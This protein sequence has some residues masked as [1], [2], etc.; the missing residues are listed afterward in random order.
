MVKLANCQ[1]EQNE[2]VKLANW[3]NEQNEQNE[4]C[5]FRFFPFCWQNEMVR[6]ANW[7]NE[8]NCHLLTLQF[9]SAHSA[10]FANFTAPV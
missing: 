5:L 4:K 2:K 7:Q 8:Q 1:N 9:H 6:L 3:Q 10:S